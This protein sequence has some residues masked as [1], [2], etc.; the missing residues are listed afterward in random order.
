MRVEREL[1]DVLGDVYDSGVVAVGDYDN[2]QTIS[3]D[4]P[5]HQKG[6]AQNLIDRRHLMF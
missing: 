3:L 5:F 1:W 2:Q 6:Y 4:S